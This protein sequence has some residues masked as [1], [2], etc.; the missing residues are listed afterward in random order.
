MSCGDGGSAVPEP[1][2]SSGWDVIAII[3]ELEI[4]L[5]SLKESN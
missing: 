4:M 3:L 1:S 2:T 5:L